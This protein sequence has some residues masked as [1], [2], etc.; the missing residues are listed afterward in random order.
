MRKTGELVK[1]TYGANIRS[2]ARKEDL[3]KNAGAPFLSQQSKYLV[4][5][6]IIS[7]QKWKKATLLSSNRIPLVKPFEPKYD[8]SFL[9]NLYRKITPHTGIVC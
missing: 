7:D 2:N 8:F 5:S 3:V 1:M 9:K 6:L 4:T